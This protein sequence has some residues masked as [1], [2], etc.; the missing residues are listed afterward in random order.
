MLFFDDFFFFRIITVQGWSTGV[1][2]EKERSENGY[3]MGLLN[4]AFL[5]FE[6][7][8]LQYARRA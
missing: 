7:Q 5:H 3:N 2:D 4:S 6:A 1:C 8:Q